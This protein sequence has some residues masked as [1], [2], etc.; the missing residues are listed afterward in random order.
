MRVTGNIEEMILTG[1]P[2]WPAERTLLSTGILEAA[3]LSRTNGQSRLVTEWLNVEYQR[4]EM[5]YF[6]PTGPRPTGAT[7]LP[8]P[9][10][11]AA[12]L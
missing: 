3:L 11:K 2:S 10:A 9:P 6:I 8:W 1:E 5:P 4:K 7:L 12:H